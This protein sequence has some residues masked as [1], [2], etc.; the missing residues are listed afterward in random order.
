MKDK[1]IAYL[2]WCL[3]VGGQ[4]NTGYALLGY[5]EMS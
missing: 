3:F 5:N 2:M 1:G 4:L